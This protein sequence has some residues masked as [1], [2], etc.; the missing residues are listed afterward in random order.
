ML[1]CT[2]H[3]LSAGG[4]AHGTL[5]GRCLSSV[6]GA[7]AWSRFPHQPLSELLSVS[8]SKGNVRV[9]AAEASGTEAHQ[10]VAQLETKFTPL[11]FLRGV[12]GGVEVS[13]HKAVPDAPRGGDRFAE[14]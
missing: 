5:T 11:G 8:N 4:R 14:A 13:E 6:P 10:V 12:G 2:H 9:R 3:S 1:A 7:V